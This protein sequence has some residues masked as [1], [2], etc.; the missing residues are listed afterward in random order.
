MPGYSGPMKVVM[1]DVEANGTGWQEASVEL[2]KLITEANRGINSASWKGTSRESFLRE[3]AQ[4]ES[5]LAK[6][7]EEMNT[8]G[9]RLLK[10]VQVLRENE[11]SLVEEA[12]LHTGLADY[13]GDFYKTG[14]DGAG[15]NGAGGASGGGIT[16]VDPTT[17]TDSPPFVPS[18]GPP[19]T[20]GGKDLLDLLS[21]LLKKAGADGQ[22]SLDAISLVRL[23]K[24]NGGADSLKEALQ[25]L[26]DKGR[27][28]ATNAEI[29]SMIMTM[30]LALAVTPAGDV[31]DAMDF[32]TGHDIMTGE[33]GWGVRAGGAL[34]LLLIGIG[35]G[36]RKLAEAFGT[37]A[38]SADEVLDLVRNFGDD[39]AKGGN[40]AL[41][42]A[43]K[44]GKLDADTLAQLV[45]LNKDNPSAL[46]AM[47]EIV[48][49]A[50]DGAKGLVGLVG[51]LHPT[52]LARLSGLNAK[53][54]NAM[55]HIA[56]GS[57]HNGQKMLEHMAREPGGAKTFLDLMDNVVKGSARH[58]DEAVG[59]DRLV[60]KFLQGGQDSQGAIGQLMAADTLL[61]G[62][63][64]GAEVS[65]EVADRIITGRA[66]DVDLVLKH[67]N[68][69]IH[70]E[71]KTNVAAG[72]AAQ[73]ATFD[74][75]EFVKDMINHARGGGQAQDM[76]K[77]L[78]WMYH[79]SATGLE[80]V[81]GQMRRAFTDTSS[82]AYKELAN[83]LARQGKT[84]QEAREGFE[85]WIKSGGL[86][87]YDL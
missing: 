82:A 73:R 15:G 37:G 2:G 11:Q 43:L 42:N 81:E 62:K 47:N 85:A 33:S 70:V 5:K 40:D 16:S 51:G 39:L 28:K 78:V 80:A 17:P 38:K 60:G 36:W 77:N 12:R 57:I 35:V 32:L 87:K 13:K 61:K 23:G 69:L 4:M 22:L 7:Q 44:A 64:K 48:Q 25:M 41:A 30:V 1:G 79:P 31:K 71:V 59:V 24:A 52:E 56:S 68:D 84:M 67:G 34:G 63:F 45:K 49:K 66:R 14:A 76:Y 26:R 54:L 83:G 65:F 8:V 18:V 9:E 50:P 21:D 58:G 55:S 75:G 46:K 74:S 27:F 20:N 29:D 72:L 6:L 53:E 3:W 10:V 86:T 19:E